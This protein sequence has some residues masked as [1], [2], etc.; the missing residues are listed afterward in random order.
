MEIA[1]G[2]QAPGER[3][4]ARSRIVEFGD[5][6]AGIIRDVA[7]ASCDQHLT[8]VEQ[9]RCCLCECNAHVPGLRPGACSRIV[10]FR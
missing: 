9:G 1:G 7:Q 6:A 8:V 5:R 2:V 10:Q 3:P 4:G